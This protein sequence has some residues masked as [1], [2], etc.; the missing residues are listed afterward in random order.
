MKY[1]FL[2]I[3]FAC[4]ANS[5]GMTIV[6]NSDSPKHVELVA[7][8]P[9]TG[10]LGGFTPLTIVKKD[11][12]PNESNVIQPPLSLREV[13]VAMSWGGEKLVKPETKT[14]WRP[15]EKDSTMA[16][17]WVP[18]GRAQCGDNNHIC[19]IVIPPTWRLEEN[20][21]G[22]TLFTDANT[23]FKA[24]S[25]GE[26][27]THVPYR[28]MVDT[29]PNR[30]ILTHTKTAAAAWKKFGKSGK[31]GE[32]IVIP[33]N[34]KMATKENSVIITTDTGQEIIIP[35]TR[36]TVTDPYT[37]KTSTEL[38]ANEAAS[39][40]AIPY[41]RKNNVVFETKQEDRVIV[42]EETASKPLV[43][44]QFNLFRRFSPQDALPAPSVRR[45]PDR[46][47]N[48]HV[49]EIVGSGYD[50][51]VTLA[52]APDTTATEA[53]PTKRIQDETSSNNVENRTYSRWR[54]KAVEK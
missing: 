54:R 2:A 10:P 12:Q 30:R 35:L 14:L 6:N 1:L 27:L 48:G 41:R 33:Q 44:P 53:I 39:L 13:G 26:L 23:S 38:Y 21:R 5:Y 34:W 31:P 17:K 22:V 24:A 20:G 50:A 11:L 40:K 47:G 25:V 32:E 19:D 4:I 9:K 28:R 16:Q 49:F 8:V 46:V 7:Y 37:K 36:K 18:L 43:T 42:V 51:D 29:I 52:Y 45:V 3:S 15:V